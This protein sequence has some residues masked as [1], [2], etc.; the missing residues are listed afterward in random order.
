MGEIIYFEYPINLLKTKAGRIVHLVVICGVP[1]SGKTLLAKD[2]CKSSGYKH[3]NPESGYA[4][5]EKIINEMFEEI[6]VKDHNEKGFVLE[7]TLVWFTYLYSERVGN[8]LDNLEIINLEIPSR[9]TRFFRAL[10]RYILGE[11]HKT[12]TLRG[13]FMEYL[14]KKPW[15]EPYKD[16]VNEYLK[17]KKLKRVNQIVSEKL[18]DS[19]KI[20]TTETMYKQ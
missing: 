6:L 2:I 19:T 1:A 15:D 13:I 16:Y 10:E 18:V 12:D 8:F 17:N 11:A 5:P 9:L 14:F 4:N 20:A 3:L 7:G